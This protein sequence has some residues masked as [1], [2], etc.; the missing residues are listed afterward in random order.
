[1]MRRITG[2][3]LTALAIFG[4]TREGTPGA[5]GKMMKISVGFETQRS[6]DM[7]DDTRTYVLKGNE[8]RWADADIDRLIYVFDTKETKNIFTSTS[9]TPE[10]TR[11][12]T[13]NIS[14]GSE[15]YMILWS[16]KSADEDE[17][18]L[19]RETGEEETVGTGAEPIGEG[20]TIEYETKASGTVTRTYI[21]GPSLAVVNPQNI[22]FTNSFASDANIAV[23]LP[24]DDKLKSVFGFLRYRIPAGPDGSAA[25]KSIT[26]SADEY[27]AGTVSIDCTGGD[28]VAKVV[29]DGCNTLTVNTGWQDGD[30]GYYEP[31]VLYAVLP[32]GTYHNMKVRITPFAG[33]ARSL[34]AETG[35]PFTISCKGDV[36][37]RR[38]CYSDLGTLPV[39]KPAPTEPGSLF[40]SDC[41]T[42]FVDPVSGIVSYRLKSE[43]VGW[44]NSQSV[45]Y[46]LKEMT[47]DERFIMFLAS[48]NEFRP[49]YHQTTHSAFV[50][51]LQ[52]RQLHQF[53]A[54]HGYPCLDPVEDKLY[55][56][57]LNKTR[58]GGQFFRRDLLVDPDKDIP[59][60]EFPST[61]VARGV[62]NPISRALSHITLT[63]DKQKV[64]IDAWIYDVFRWGMLDLYT[65]KWDEWGM[66]TTVHITHGQ[67]NPKHD[68]EALCSVDS[69]DDRQGVH[70]PVENDP[71]GTY[72]RMQYTKKNYRQ[73]I[74]PNPDVNSATHDGW[75]P[76]GDHVFW[77]SQG[78]NIR[79]IRTGEY[80]WVLKLDPS[81]DCAAHCHP[82]Q[83]LEYW[84][85]DNNY[86]D[87]Y[88]GCRWKIYFYNARTGR[89]VA[90]YSGLP[91]ITTYDKPSRIHPDP[92]PHFVCNDKYIICTAAGD[93]GNLHFSITPVDQLIALTQ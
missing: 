82:S 2:I 18:E 32:A 31:G 78:I 42:R 85:F 11:T 66:S 20:G 93:D 24:G 79:N 62:N 34:D 4:C 81:N 75:A 44:D 71:D 37:I 55:Y 51:D 21:T 25:I 22:D 12:F 59:L 76:D 46:M 17:S 57:V 54:P 84:T 30:G 77:C 1:M 13:G 90:I 68:D 27:L 87:Y 86:P 48:G 64:F 43:A 15:I 10:A 3:F 61:I 70:H 40:G 28:P 14:E 53:P 8:I 7:P 45:Y 56:F 23:M 16:G 73:T 69:W 60:A 19:S 9:A 65:G 29:N 83:N 50:L 36:T 92:H 5:D 89:R 39:T 33:S 67:I 91:A 58:D 63:S 72:P 52:T 74:Q 38:G 49:D 6:K 47:D 88:R 80:E 35:A 41:F 26:V